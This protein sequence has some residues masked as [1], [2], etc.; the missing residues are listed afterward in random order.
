[1]TAAKLRS[2]CEQ[3]ECVNTSD[4]NGSDEYALNARMKHC[5]AKLGIHDKGQSVCLDSPLPSQQA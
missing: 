4:V 3:A 5:D 2:L 1:V